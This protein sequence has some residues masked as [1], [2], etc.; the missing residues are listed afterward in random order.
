M[1]QKKWKCLFNQWWFYDTLIKNR[2]ACFCYLHF[3][4]D[5]TLSKVKGKL[6]SPVQFF[7]TLWTVS[8]MAP[9]SIGFSR[10][11]YCSGLPFSSPCDLPNPGIELG[12]PALQT[13]A[14]S[15]EPLGKPSEIHSVMSDS[16]RPQ[17]LYSPWDSPGQNT[18]ADNLS[19]LQGIFPTQGSNP[20]LPH[21]RQIL[22]QLSHKGS[23]RILEW[24]ACPFSSRSSLPRNWTQVSCIA[25]RFFAS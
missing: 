10:Q 18:G 4:C 1:C 14:L 17:G 20:D 3:H 23:P 12:S 9:W 22:C 8:Y 7:A 16:L 13:D 11:E 5:L 2:Y 15:S 25:G 19:L 24:V 21:C 6:V